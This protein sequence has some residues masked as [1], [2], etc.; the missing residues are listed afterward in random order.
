LTEGDKMRKRKL[1]W[2]SEFVATQILGRKSNEERQ[3]ATAG[4][5]KRVPLPRLGV[6]IDFDN[7]SG[8]VIPLVFEHLSTQWDSTWRRA[9]GTGLT[10]YKSLFHSSGILPIE[11]VP[12]T[13]GKN[14][15]DIALVIDVVLAICSDSVDAVC[16]VSSDGDYTRL[17]LTIR[18]KGKRV[19]IV[20]RSK[21]PPSLRSAC[22]EFINLDDLSNT[23]PQ[24][25]KGSGR[26]STTAPCEAGSLGFKGN[27]IEPQVLVTPHI[28]GEQQPS[29]G[30]PSPERVKAADL[31]PLIRE[32]TGDRGKTTLKAIHARCSQRYASFSPRIYGAGK[33]LALLRKMAVFTI[34]PIQDKKTGRILDYAIG[35]QPAVQAPEVLTD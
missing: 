22:T 30:L 27:S 33:W 5:D 7:V 19:L 6:F 4:R 13:P 11:V 15:T 20:G 28:N 16:I 25:S 26:L 10:K 17:A 1:R 8:D 23:S 14:S 18:E 35:F 32:L 29:P 21:T 12:N 31:I 3:K 9:Y 34:D 24:A 2:F